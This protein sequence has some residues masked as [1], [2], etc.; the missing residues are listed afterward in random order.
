MEAV[1]DLLPTTP[2]DMED[3]LST[4][5]TVNEVDGYGNPVKI[6]A[7][8]EDEVLGKRFWQE[9]VNTY[10]TGSD[11]WSKQ[12]GRLTKAVVRRKR[13]E[14]ANDGNYDTGLT[15]SRTSTFSYFNTTDHRKGLLRTAVR[16]AVPDGSRVKLAAHTTTYG[17]DRFGN[18]VRAAVR[19][20]RRATGSATL[21]RCNRD[22]LAYDA[23]GRY[24]VAETDCLGRVRRE[25]VVRNAHG[26]VEEEKW[27][28]DQGGVNGVVTTHK[29]TVGGRLYFSR[30][31]DGAYTGRVRADCDSS[32]PSGAE[33]YVETRQG[34]GGAAREY[35]DVLGRVVRSAVRGF[36]GRWVNTDT[37]YDSLGRVTRRSEPYYAGAV[38]Q[39]WTRFEYDLLGRVVVRNALDEVVRTA[40]HLGTTVSHGYDAWGQ[41]TRT[42]T[43]ARESS[44]TV[45]MDYDARG[46][47]IA[48]RDPD[49]GEWT[50][51]Y[52][53]FDELLKQTDALGNYQVLGYDGL[54]RVRTRRDYAPGPTATADV[55]W[56]YDGRNGLGQLQLVTDS[57]SGYVR[58]HDYDSLGRADTQT[59][60]LGGDGSYPS[61]QTYDGY[62]RVHQVFDAAR[63][64]M[65]W[66]DNVTEV[67]YNKHGYAHRWV[68]GV[69]VGG[70]SRRTY[71]EI[72]FR[73]ARGKVT[74]EALGGGAIR[75][76]RDFDNKTGRIESITSRDALRRD[77][78]ALSYE[79]DRVGNLTGR[80][81][82]SVGKALTEAFTYDTLNRLTR[83]QVTGET[84]ETTPPVVR[85]A[86]TV[87]YD[88]LGNIT[89]KSDVGTADYVYGS[90]RPHAVTAAGGH[91]YT[92][93]A[94]GN[95]LTDTRTGGH[96]T[97]S[98]TYT[99]FNKVAAL[100]R[101]TA[102]EHTRATA[103]IYGPDRAR[104]KRTDTVVT[105]SGTSTTTTLYLGNVEQVIAPDGSYTFKRYI[106]AGVLVTQACNRRHKRTGEAVQYLLYDHLGSLDVITDAA[107]AVAQDMS[108]DAWGQRR[109]PDDWTVLA[110]LR[111]KDMS[112]ARI[113]PYGF[114][115]HEM[116][117]A[118]GII[119]MNGRIYDAKLGRFM[120][121]DPVIQF[122]D[123]SQ[124]WN[125]Y[126]Y[127]LNN[128]LAYTDPSGY[129]LGIVG[130]I[131][132]GAIGFIT[133]GPACA[134]KGAAIG[135]GLGASAEVLIRGGNLG[136]ALLAGV[137]AAALTYAAGSLFPGLGAPFGEVLLYGLQMGVIGGITTTLQGG[138]FGHGFVAAGTAALVGGALART[139][140]FQ[141][142]GKV[143]KFVTSAVAGG[144]VS[145][146]TG[147]K[148]ANGA[149]TAA[150]AYMLSSAAQAAAQRSIQEGMSPAEFEA[151]FGITFEDSR[152][153]YE[154]RTGEPFPL[155]KQDALRLF[156]DEAF[157][158]KQLIANE[159]L[160]IV[161]RNIL[162]IHAAD[163]IAAASTGGYVRQP[164]YKN[165]FHNPL[166]NTKWVGPYGHFEV[167]F[168]SNN[169]LITDLPYKGT[170]NFF[171]PADGSA[172]WKADVGPYLN[173]RWGN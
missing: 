50:Y 103:F 139:G 105:G 172:H 122:P 20:G 40:D 3:P 10:G 98:F 153:E 16:A 155:T 161:Y 95:M 64:M 132:G 145:R 29:Y 136:Q 25:V 81:E 24:V 80:T 71:R 56:S 31:A 126:S 90:T 46:R 67:R 93:D 2:N 36:D 51:A 4:V 7:T 1:Y 78:Q 159:N 110:L 73:D 70:A 143:G 18:R 118:H 44:V 49:R 5:T 66:D 26:L 34:G 125:R 113:T 79:W 120:Q 131:I 135:A 160:D 22:T 32:C 165:L 150:F 144:T 108:F 76:R 109:A 117:D 133:C 141:R 101:G 138:R 130:G 148:F 88:A 104:T 42:T 74:G 43:G 69:Y 77:I 84:G 35:A 140:W 163:S 164:W 128:P 116:L 13:N 55:I 11:T 123:Y 52:N 89:N 106:T 147:G 158:Q 59:V 167:V 91:T 85:A 28:V 168:D 137:S 166:R 21:R 61:K 23:Y 173:K 107:G 146:I 58:Y 96:T 115:G 72:T 37:E 27:L 162:N 99:A 170:F 41:V 6:T 14:T 60:Q 111:L 151:R 129:I 97:R 152:F 114:T 8:T 57:K 149:L 48:L 124:S 12:F 68:D 75:T 45:E 15:G 121:A 38:K 19:A 47:R 94:N 102:D 87:R 53:G 142:L 9:T 92:Y 82:T 17:Y 63:R 100:Y 86:Q 65:R 127:V 134:V 157:A 30:V 33:Y 171:S 112:H 83:S 169:E 119:H 154:S 39:Y 156:T 62:G 54:G